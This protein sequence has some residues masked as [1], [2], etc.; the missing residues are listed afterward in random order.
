MARCAE[1]RGMDR[2]GYKVD[3]TAACDNDLPH[4]LRL[5]RTTIAV[6]ADIQQLPLCFRLHPARSG[7][8]S[9]RISMEI[10]STNPLRCHPLGLNLARTEGAAPVLRSG[11]G[12]GMYWPGCH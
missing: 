7:P 11:P 10:G 6:E 12:L 2:I 8:R 4:L 5:V 9:C 3:I 1:K